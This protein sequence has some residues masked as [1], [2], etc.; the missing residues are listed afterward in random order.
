MKIS[1]YAVKNYQFTLILFLMVVA[2]GLSTM[3]TMPRSED[4]EVKFPTFPIIVVFP[5][6]S[7][8]DME[9]LVVEPIEKKIAELE[10]IKNIKSVIKDGL[11][12]ISPDFKYDTNIDDNYQELVREINAIRTKLPAD[13]HSIEIIKPSPSLVKIIQIA[14]ISENSSYGA[15]KKYA[16][17]LQD[18]LEKLPMLKNV[19]IS[20]LPEQIIRVDLNFDKIAQ[21]NIPLNAILGNIRSEMTTIPGGE[22]TAGKK[23]FNII[24]TGNFNT[25]EKIKNSVIF[26]MNGSLILLKDIANVQTDYDEQKHITR[27]NGHRCVFV[28]AAQKPEFNITSTQKSYKPV[29]DKF[30]QTLPTNIQMV[31]NFDQADNVN[32][33]LRGLGEDFLIAILLVSITLLPLGFRA[34]SVVMISIPL[35]LLMGVTLLHFMGFNLNQLS[36]VGFVVALGLLVDDSIVVVENIERWLRE[37]HSR[38]EA[39]FKATK[40]IGLA[41]IGCTITLVIAFLPLVFMPDASGKFIRSLPMAVLTTVLASL[42]V[43]LT[44][45]PFLCSIILKENYHDSEGNIFL[46]AIKNGIKKF[47]GPIL[48][49]A[50]K[51]PIVTILIALILFIGS[52]KLIPLIGFSLFPPSEKPQFLVNIVTP[53]QSNLEYS[54]VIAKDVEKILD[55]CPEIKYYATNVGKGNPQIYYNLMPENERT[56]YAQV[57]V[58]LYENT[59]PNRKMALI[60]ELRVKFKNLTGAKIEV[61]NFE[62][63]PPVIAPVEIKLFGDNLDTLSVLASKIEELLKNT[64]GTMYVNNPISNKKSDIRIKVNKAK[65]Q[66]YGVISSD[67]YR[68]VRMVVAGL[69]MG[70]VSLD[71]DDDYDLI[72]TS[73]KAEH[74][75]MEVFDKLFV[76]NFQGKAIPI[77]QIAN[78]ELETSPVSI[79]HLNKIRT[80]SVTAYVK[81][82]YLNDNVNKNVIQKMNLFNLPKGYNYS[83]GGEL[84]SREESFGGFGTIIIITVFLFLAVL[85]LEFKTFKSSLIVL[86]VIPLGIVGA[87]SALLITGNS[88]SF[89]AIIGLI[90]LA[91]IEV[92][93]SILLVDFTNQLRIEGKPMDEAIREAGEVR[94]F[95]IL[96]TTLTAIFGLLPIAISTNPLIS[97]LAIVIIGGLISSTILSRVIT[98]VLYKLLPPKIEVNK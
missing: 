14:L 12:V 59:S 52:I 46:K 19:D 47:Y 21:M 1:E 32:K 17:R 53:L 20:G 81:N 76:N 35:S 68:N 5:G 43:A 79:Q 90:A 9:Q 83:M 10:N 11:A 41:V 64:E 98:P 34:A 31:Q 36:I 61:K 70:N 93:N 87:V 55:K 45:I 13:I 37:G 92:K 78:L 38:K 48:D 63:G 22:I 86:S 56:D 84:E 62:Q 74:A 40:Q 95:P 2:V 8:Q 72:V 80:V 54:N 50:L 23:S 77:R 89:V 4:P 75:T 51:K 29:L 44:I 25:I 58:Q 39:I 82:G 57:F 24:T 27:L 30:K 28:S 97:P 60:E 15:I 65:A 67:I 3:F 26:S 7:P 73:S 6:T 85:I 66:M 33:R 69:N 91:G 16:E 96:L 42:L 94:F 88:M 71:N 49:W 18:E